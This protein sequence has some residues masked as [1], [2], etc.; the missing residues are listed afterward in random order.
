M[1]DQEK[2]KLIISMIVEATANNG[3]EGVS[4]N[5]QTIK[6]IKVGNRYYSVIS[7]PKFKRIL[8]D[9]LVENR[10][11]LFEHPQ[12]VF[13]K[14]VAQR[15]PTNTNPKA[16]VLLSFLGYM[17]TDSS[18]SG[19]GKT[20]VRKSALDVM[21]IRSITPYQYDSL[22]HNNNGLIRSSGIQMEHQGSNLYK[23]EYHVSLYPI[24]IVLHLDSLFRNDLN[25]NLN[26][27][28]F[29]PEYMTDCVLAMLE[30]LHIGISD[31][32]LGIHNT[33]SP[34][35]FH[36]F[37]SRVGRNNAKVWAYDVVDDFGGLHVNILDYWRAFID[38][39]IIRTDK[40]GKKIFGY[41]YHTR[42]VR[43]DEKDKSIFLHCASS[44]NSAWDTFANELRNRLTE[45]FTNAK[46]GIIN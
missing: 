22:L 32:S 35:Y 36:A 30:E 6:K 10:R 25:D 1:K 20:L 5:E 7:I 37:L 15:V 17:C 42:H 12:V 3:D 13:D 28:Q 16:D 8:Q 39:A 23:R 2:L 27:Q 11:D 44:G 34:L 33:L 26:V 46:N 40:E 21:F 41:L 18:K 29:T 43:I 4:G 45:F 19:S 14:G 31:T 24:H 9:H 38:N